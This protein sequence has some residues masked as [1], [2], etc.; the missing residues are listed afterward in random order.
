MIIILL[1]FSS[2]FLSANE[3]EK[4]TDLV[5]VTT[6]SSV[7]SHSRNKFYLLFELNIKDEW[8]TYWRNPGD[9]GLP[10]DLQIET[11]NDIGIS[12]I[13]WVDIPEKIPFA[14]LAN[15]GFSG[16]SNLV[17]QINP[18][19]WGKDVTLKAKISW[20]VCKEECIPQDTTI[21][22]TIPYK[23]EKNIDEA[24]NEYIT[25]LVKNS[26]KERILKNAKATLVGEEIYLS[27][28]ENLNEESKDIVFFPYEGGVFSN[29]K[30]QNVNLINNTTV[31]I[32]PL[33]EFRIEIP[34]KLT[35]LIVYDKKAFE[36]SVD[37]D[38]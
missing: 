18:D 26:P 9:S 21:E 31:M 6:K 23:K 14:D 15:F 27:F 2:L 36:I 24:I 25:N 1:F 33:D 32:L 29:A 3:S 11:D 12:G 13:M 30:K 38:K 5:K 10:T 28:D 34:E 4:E 20:L 37:I 16:K 17:V 7:I 35:G 19:D 22:I 8:H